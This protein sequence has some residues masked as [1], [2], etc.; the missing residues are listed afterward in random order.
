MPIYTGQQNV[1]RCWNLNGLPTPNVKG[2]MGVL[3]AYQKAIHGTKLAGP[4]YFGEF[5][6]KVKSEL[7]ENV[8]RGGI[9]KNRIYSVII[10]ITD[11]NC[12]DMEITK[13]LLIDMS[14]MPFSAVVVGVGDSDF[15]D[16]E[17]LDADAMVLSDSKGREACRDIVQL[18]KYTDFK[19]LGMRELALEVLGE[20]PD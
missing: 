19:D 4:T 12:H 14:Q 11:G 9:F 6:G 10:I 18:V 16:M 7:I 1:S 3:E 17:V 15:A 5:L 8:S 13:S 20:V 2:T